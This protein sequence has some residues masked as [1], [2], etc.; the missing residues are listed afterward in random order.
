MQLGFLRTRVGRRFLATNLVASSLL[1]TV[2]ALASEA[3]VRSALRNE[4]E[5]RLSRLAKSLSLSTLAT[6]ATA[7]RDLEGDMRRG[8]IGSSNA[9]TL[10]AHVVRSSRRGVPLGIDDS[11]MARAL[12]AE[13]YA[14][15]R[16][17]RSLLVVR[18]T[19][20]E[21]LILLGRAMLRGAADFDVAWARVNDGYLWGTADE[22]IGGE[23]AGYCVAERQSLAIVHCT[24]DMPRASVALAS[25]IAAQ[26]LDSRTV[27]DD[28]G[29][30]ASTRDVYLRYEFGAAEWRVI[31]IQPSSTAM[32]ALASFRRMI[33][34]LFIA[35]LTL[36]FLVSHAQIRRTTEPLARLREG[37]E[38]LQ[39]GDFSAPVVVRSNDEFEDVAESFNGM[40]RELDQQFALLR[41]M[42]AIDESALAARERDALVRE[43]AARFQQ[44]LSSPRVAIAVA[45][46]SRPMMIDVAVT[47]GGVPAPAFLSRRLSVEEADALRAQPRQF[48]LAQGARVPSYVGGEVRGALQQGVVVLPLWQDAELLGV[49]AVWASDDAL[50]HDA[51]WRDARRMADRV[52]LALRHV[53]LVHRL[54]ALSA[55]TI[56]AFARAIDA[57]SPWTAGHSE[58][59]TRVAVQVGRELQLP[60]DDMATLERGALLHD[61]GKIAV[62]A[63]VLDKQGRLTDAEWTVMMRHPVVGCEILGPIPALAETLPLVRSHHERMDGTGY[64]DRLAGDDI[65]FLARVLAVADVFDALSS[66]RPYREG[67]GLSEACQIIRESAGSHLDPHVVAAFLE[68]V[69]KGNLPA[70]PSRLDT[71]TLAAAVASARDG[72]L[73]H[74]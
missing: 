73:T 14:H 68:V 45:H 6:L 30:F 57:N 74:A 71:S 48:V 7:V 51:P 11:T 63:S 34:I 62:P 21:S 22:S 64:P 38:R 54:N 39:Q 36:I 35:A 8:A 56:T 18:R 9:A 32:A 37:T 44:L 17:G 47:E 70:Q 27:V 1:L 13:E 72:L 10:V 23:D 28:N 67:L 49:V 4:A 58:R 20:D 60:D 40:A 33:A 5:A 15:L 69:R 42:D 66:E 46:A 55:G 29:R 24:H 3:Y 2:I 65:P 31:V 25:R 16:G 41:N 19:G 53:Q 43:A 59:V 52:A 12:T 26:T 61:I 50:A